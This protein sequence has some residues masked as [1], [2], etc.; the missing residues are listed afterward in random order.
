MLQAYHTLK[1]P[2]EKFLT[3]IA[4]SKEPCCTLYPEY[5]LVYICYNIP[6][7]LEVKLEY[8][9]ILVLVKIECGVTRTRS[10]IFGTTSLPARCLSS[11]REL[12]V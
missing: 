6:I 9:L 8:A 3:Q 4:L 10:S 2:L 1:L 5:L 11:A 12:S 7:Y